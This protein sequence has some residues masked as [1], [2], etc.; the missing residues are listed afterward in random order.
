MRPFCRPIRGIRLKSMMLFRDAP[1]AIRD[2]GIDALLIDQI[3][4]VGGTVAEH[5]GL[6]FVSVAAALPINTDP[7]VPPTNFP[8]FA[9]SCWHCCP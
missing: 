9:L 5:R 4:L 3:E 2:E 8:C 1:A 7:S 6:P